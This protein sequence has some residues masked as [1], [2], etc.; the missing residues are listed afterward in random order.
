MKELADH[1]SDKLKVS[2]ERPILKGDKHLGSMT[3][4][5][6]QKIWRMDSRTADIKEAEYE[7]EEFRLNSK[8]EAFVHKKLK[9][10]KGYLYAAAI[11]LKNAEK[12][13]VKQIKSLIPQKKK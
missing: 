5:K 9:I 4:H 10:E 3:V 7:R 2:E 6:G 12:K 1:H 11:N 13:F 8:G